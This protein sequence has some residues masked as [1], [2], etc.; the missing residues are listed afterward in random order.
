V[1]IKGDYVGHPFRGNQWTDAAGVPREG[2]RSAPDHDLRPRLIEW[3]PRK[4][5]TPD[6]SVTASEFKALV[7]SDAMDL[8]VRGIKDPAVRE[9]L[10]RFRSQRA[11]V[12]EGAQTDEQYLSGLEADSAAAG[13][14]VFMQTDAAAKVMKAI[15]VSQLAADLKAQGISDDDAAAAIAVIEANTVADYSGLIGEDDARDTTLLAHIVVQRWA[16]SSNDK[17]ALSLAI[18]D[19]AARGGGVGD[20]VAV[21]ANPTADPKGFV[22]MRQMQ[23]RRGERF[24]DE[25]LERRARTIADDPTS[26]VVIAAALQ[27]QYDRTQ[28][29]L[30]ER[31]IKSVSVF[32]GLTHP[33]MAAAAE[34]ALREDDELTQLR[35]DL[36]KAES[37]LTSIRA[38]QKTHAASLG[39]ARTDK[40]SADW[41]VRSSDL[42]ERFDQGVRQV[43]SARR[44]LSDAQ[45]DVVFS[46]EMLT[47]PLSA[48]SSDVR[49]AMQFAV[50]AQAEGGIVMRADV[51]SR[52]VYSVPLTGS[53]CLNEHEVILTTD[54]L[55][56][57]FV[58]RG[59]LDDVRL[60]R[61]PRERGGAQP[62]TIRVGDE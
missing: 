53:G 47:R 48:F 44:T 62:R 15:V 7:T 34:K 17:D 3:T 41:V 39:A 35:V 24:A 21:Q 13:H 55:E 58:N 46:A 12:A 33:T 42:R 9:V 60:L 43:D 19:I 59:T 6:G 27:A 36:E 22:G 52:I 16:V 2:A 4:V 31:G 37:E 54:A 50:E 25:D 57:V 14:D 11:R 10:I 23:G 29:Y 49:T 8:A 40:E 56:A 45:R 5:D 1:V 26:A 32:R 28:Q 20:G 51:S 38:E 18:Q 61:S 30:A